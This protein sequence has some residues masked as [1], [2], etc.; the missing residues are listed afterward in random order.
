M[1]N[2]LPNKTKQIAFFLVKLTIV[3]GACYFIYNK[4]FH[5]EHVDY[6]SFINQLENSV[7]NDVTTILLLIGFSITNWFLEILKWKT[8]ASTIRKITFF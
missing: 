8:L 6:E 4:L 7:F 3:G 1:Y 5:N 2:Q